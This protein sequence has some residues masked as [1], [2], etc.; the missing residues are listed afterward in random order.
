MLFRR[1]TQSNEWNRKDRQVL[2]SCQGAEIFFIHNKYYRSP[3]IPHSPCW[4]YKIYRLDL[5]RGVRLPDEIPDYGTKQS[6][7]EVPV[8]LELWGMWSTPVLQSLLDSYW[9]GVLIPDR[10]L[11]MGQLEINCV[12]M[13]NWTA[14]KRTVLTFGRHTSARLICLKWNCFSMRNWII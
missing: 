6:D 13:L 10:V 1:T 14:W 12:L 7:C 4:G 11:S 8:M 3:S 9:P 5:C 2:R